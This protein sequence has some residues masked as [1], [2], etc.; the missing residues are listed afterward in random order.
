[1]STDNLFKTSYRKD[2]R[3]VV[4]ANILESVQVLRNSSES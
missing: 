3:R 4:L 1:M 2:C